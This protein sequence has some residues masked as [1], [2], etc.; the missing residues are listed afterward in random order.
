MLTGT[1]RAAKD[2]VARIERVANDGLAVFIE[3][4]SGSG[5]D[6]VARAIHEASDRAAGPFVVLDCAAIAHDV[7][8]CVL[9]GHA[10][11]A[12]EGAVEAREGFLEAANGGTLVLGDVAEL[13]FELQA[14]VARVLETRSVTRVGDDEPRALDVRV[15]TTTS[16]DARML[17]ADG[18]L[19]ADLFSSL[20]KSR[21]SVPSLAMRREDIASI[22]DELLRRAAS[23]TGRVRTLSATARAVL[24]AH[25]YAGNVRELRNVIDRATWLCDGSVIEPSHLTFDDVLRLSDETITEE[26]T[27]DTLEFPDFKEAKRDVV[28]DFE[29]QYLERLLARTRG[30]IAMSAGIAGLERH[31]LRSL[32][33]KHGLYAQ[34]A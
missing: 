23:I 13:P 19:D 32:L 1:S 26:T 22:A 5:K 16:R 34:A 10:A 24:A 8:E 28:D 31:Y 7:A 6:L 15:M 33:R 2:L 27:M 20:A 3:G 14:A 9:F 29:R 17:L 11:G 30:N 18:V 21:V 12:F 4:P 25:D